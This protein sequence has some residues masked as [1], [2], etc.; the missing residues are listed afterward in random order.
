MS[1]TNVFSLK[2]VVQR[3]AMFRK[4]DSIIVFF[5]ARTK[6]KTTMAMTIFREINFIIVAKINYRRYLNYLGHR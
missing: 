6:Y 1:A 5:L 3:T 2:K 4:M